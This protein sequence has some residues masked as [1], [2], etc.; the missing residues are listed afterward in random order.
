MLAEDD[1]SRTLQFGV[2]GRYERDN[3][4]G[5]EV[6]EVHLV[7]RDESPSPSL[8]AGRAQPDASCR[9]IIDLNQRVDN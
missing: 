9:H 8:G 3:I 7:E 6:A 4:V 1:G 5:R 2:A